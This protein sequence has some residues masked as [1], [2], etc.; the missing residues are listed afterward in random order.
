M[1]LYAKKEKGSASYVMCVSV[2][3]CVLSLSLSLSL[4]LDAIGKRGEREKEEEC[5]DSKQ[6]GG[7]T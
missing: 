5:F 7:K 6:S 2:C 3:V 1:L 4:F